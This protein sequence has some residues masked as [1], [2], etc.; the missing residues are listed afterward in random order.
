MDSL[1]DNLG[2]LMDAHAEAGLRFYNEKIKE[3]LPMNP[4]RLSHW[5][6]LVANA[7]LAVPRTIIVPGLSTEELW[8][9][10]DGK[11]PASMDRIADAIN[12]AGDSVGWPC[13]LRT[14]L[15]SYKHDW[16]ESCFL[17]SPL[18]TERHVANLCNFSMM[19]DF[20]GLDCSEF[21]VRELLQTVSSF[22]AFNGMPV[23]REVRFFFEGGRISGY[24]P[25]WPEE[26]IETPSVE[27]W[28]SKLACVQTF[29]RDEI[30]HIAG[31]ALIAGQAASTSGLCSDWSVDFLYVIDRGW[32]LIDMA[33]A[34]NSYRS[35]DFTRYSFGI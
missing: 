3:S 18:F 1:P 9:I 35:P 26:S 25:Y 5:F 8:G 32:M 10:A 12:D 28:R 13:F 23:A 29:T 27:D 19:A 30:A 17:S 22:A 2:D 6:P 15:T 33:E 7:G 20:I 34:G 16:Q 24:Q 21:V 11:R 14:G 31:F 4:T